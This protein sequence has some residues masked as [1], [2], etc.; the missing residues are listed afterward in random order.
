MNSH[1][2]TPASG[3]T[4]GG[5]SG[6]DGAGAAVL[7]TNGLGLAAPTA[8][9]NVA[10]AG[11]GNREVMLYECDVWQKWEVQGAEGGGGGGRGGRV[12]N[13][14]E[15][16]ACTRQGEGGWTDHCHLGTGWCCSWTV[17]RRGPTCYTGTSNW[18]AGRFVDAGFSTRRH[19]DSHQNSNRCYTITFRGT[20]VSVLGCTWGARGGVA[21]RSTL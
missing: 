18:G 17:R 3:S 1:D 10:A 5:P 16:S 6:E 15:S 19:F 21:K 7:L 20:V 9:A 2:M 12:M 4:S 13:A 8:G 11:G 14:Q